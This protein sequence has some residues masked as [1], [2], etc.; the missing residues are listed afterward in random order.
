MPVYNA[1]RYVAE[2]ARSVLGQTFTDFEFVVIDDGSTDG[3]AEVVEQAAAGDPRLRLVRQQNKGVSAAS[4]L[5][6]ELARGEFL[7]RVD[8]DDVCCPERLA[9][10]VAF[11][12]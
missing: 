8:A 11:L 7:A 5:G 12:R 2:A 10:Q 9:K 4:N 6:T 3:S 1:R